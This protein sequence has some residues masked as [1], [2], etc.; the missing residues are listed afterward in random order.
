MGLSSFKFFVVGSERCIFSAIVCI[1]RSRSAKV[2]DFDT[3]QKGICNFQLVINSNFGPISHRFWDTA[4]YWVKI[5]NFSYPTLIYRPR[6]RWTLSNFWMNFLSR[7]LESLG[8]EDFMILAC[9]VLTQCYR[10]RQMDGLTD[11]QTDRHPDRI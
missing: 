4:T 11:R 1:G 6:L 2:N 8:C 3:N 5:A 9:I 7:K 10:E